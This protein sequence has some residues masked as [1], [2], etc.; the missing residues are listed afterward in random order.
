MTVLAMSLVAAAVFL[1]VA[2]GALF[3]RSRMAA[4]ARA[5]ELD[6][7]TSLAEA[8]AGMATI[9]AFTLR[10]ERD[11]RYATGNV[12]GAL[13][14]W[15]GYEDDETSPREAWR[16]LV[17]P[18]DRGVVEQA[19]R[20]ALAGEPAEC[21]V[22]FVPA[23]GEPRR[24]RLGL[25]PARDRLGWVRTVHGVLREPPARPDLEASL[26]ASESRLREAGERA[27]L[28]T[29]LERVLGDAPTAIVCT[30]GL[31]RVVRVNAAGAALLGAGAQ[32]L[33]GRDFAEAAPEMWREL[34]PKFRSA[35][36]QGAPVTEVLLRWRAPSGGEPRT[37]QADVFPLRDGDGGVTGVA[38]FA[39]DI[40]GRDRV[41]RGL[42]ALVERLRDESRKKDEQLAALSSELTGRVARDEALVLRARDA[43][44]RP[45]GRVVHLIDDLL[46]ASRIA[47][48]ELVLR[49]ER[50]A[51]QAVLGRALEGRRAR[52]LR[53]DQEVTVAAPDAAV[54]LDADPARLAHAFALLLDDAGA[55]DAGEP[56]SVTV[57]CGDGS[58]TVCVR[59]AGGL[60]VGLAPVRALVERHGGTVE[61]VGGESRS[62]EVR[63]TLPIATVADGDASSRSAAAA[64][65]RA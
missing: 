61:V 32:S 22:R 48:G 12:I 55:G 47:R 63:V 16:R 13:H 33:V 24:L 52:H 62:A 6:E 15:L 29:L 57:T 19:L 10:V 42:D 53:P 46:D 37:F 26:R 51:L 4:A 38:A 44:G 30:D 34:G 23:R 9:T 5:Q 2:L 64:L 27:S 20:S 59:R 11:G 54:W 1:L 21:E 60:D 56:P 14:A 40:T 3:V 18:E 39:S 7:A 35:L 50:V 58:V 49:R 8:V 17:H 36:E 43:I 31:F 45:M 28:V 41:Q 25:R 65:E